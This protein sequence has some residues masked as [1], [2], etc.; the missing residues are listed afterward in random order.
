MTPA[1]TERTII[2]HVDDPIRSASALG[3]RRAGSE[4]GIMDRGRPRKRVGDLRLQNN[5]SML[6][7]KAAAT[8][9]SERK[10]FE[11]LPKGWT[12]SEAVNHLSTSDVEALF[13]QATGQA[14]RFEVLQPEDVESLSKVSRLFDYSAPVLTS[15]AGAP[16]VG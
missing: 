13:S 10:A 15:P 12:P 7:L 5:S 8:R 3:H 4:T 6:D 2:P 11:E 1:G 14:A 9:F 16:T